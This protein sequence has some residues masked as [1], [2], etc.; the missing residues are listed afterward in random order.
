MK[1]IMYKVKNVILIS[2]SMIMGAL[3]GFSVAAIDSFHWIPFVGLFI[4]FTWLVVFAAAN[5]AL[6]IDCYEDEG[7]EADE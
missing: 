4:S 6:D 1:K 2:I 7:D 5:G 3:F